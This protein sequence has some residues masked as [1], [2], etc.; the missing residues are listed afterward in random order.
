MSLLDVLAFLT[1]LP[2]GPRTMEGVGKSMWAFPLAGLLIALPL[3]LAAY[4]LISAG[5]DPL[6]TAALLLALLY[7]LTGIHHFD[8]LVDFADAAAKKG[9]PEERLKVL[10]DPAVGAAGF[11]AGLLT[12]LLLW[13][14]AVEAARLLDFAILLALFGSA[15]VG[16]KHAMVV[17]AAFGR[18]AGQGSGATFLGE[19]TAGRLLGSFLLTVALTFGL[20]GWAL[21]FG[22]PGGL[23]PA[24]ILLMVGHLLP[25]LIEGSARRTLGGVTGDVLGATNELARAALLVSAV[26]LI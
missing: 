26:V 1:R 10:R 22:V 19:V 18:P 6:L 14:A 13:S 8:G 3:A 21:G 9:G 5:L 11:L 4:G 15:E 25:K 17:A 12:L 20:W 24:A 2:V 16:A 7:L 23:L